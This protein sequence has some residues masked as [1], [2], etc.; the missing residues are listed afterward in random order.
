[1]RGGSWRAVVPWQALDGWHL[2]GSCEGCQV[3]ATGLAPD[4]SRAGQQDTAEAGWAQRARGLPLR[5]G[6]DQVQPARVSEGP[7]RRSHDCVMVPTGFGTLSEH[8]VP[9]Q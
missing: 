4:W 6:T 1:M 9:V 7:A 2:A 3:V 8:M 5:R